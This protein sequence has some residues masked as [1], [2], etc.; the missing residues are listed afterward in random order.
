MSG[1]TS[2]NANCEEDV[3]RIKKKLEKMMKTNEHIVSKYLMSSCHPCPI[4]V[5]Y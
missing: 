4:P 2:G 3:L 1:V 5:I